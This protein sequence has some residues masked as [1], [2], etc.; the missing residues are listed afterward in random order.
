MASSENNRAQLSAS[1]A[2]SSFLR[3]ASLHTPP[4]GTTAAVDL[5]TCKIVW[6]V[7]LGS[8][9]PGQQTGTINLGGP[10]VTAGGLVFTGATMDNSI[11]HSIRNPARSLEL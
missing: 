5:F 8:Y 7:P 11:R 1:I 4:W 2:L 9:V 6:N 3:E 10:M